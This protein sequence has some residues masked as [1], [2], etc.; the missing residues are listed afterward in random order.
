MKPR[1]LAC[2]HCRRH[3]LQTELQCPF[4]SGPTGPVFRRAPGA[5]LPRERLGSVA[6]F[7]FAVASSTACGGNTDEVPPDAGQRT[8]RSERDGSPD[9]DTQ[10]PTADAGDGGMNEPI[11]AGDPGWEDDAGPVPIY[12]GVPEG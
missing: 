7:T 10:Q 8:D 5:R 1:L 4:C 12:R 2:S 11:D 3:I 6:L 9:D